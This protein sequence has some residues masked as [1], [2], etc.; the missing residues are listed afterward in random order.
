MHLRCPI[1]LGL[2]EAT[3]GEPVTES[4]KK[5]RGYKAELDKTEAV[6][7]LICFQAFEFGVTWV[8]ARCKR[9]FTVVACC[10]LQADVLRD[11]WAPYDI[12]SQVYNGG[13]RYR[14][15]VVQASQCRCARPN[16]AALRTSF[17]GFACPC[18][19]R[20]RRTQ[21]SNLISTFWDPGADGLRWSRWN[22]RDQVACLIMLEEPCVLHVNTC[23]SAIGSSSSMLG[24]SAILLLLL[25][26]KDY[27]WHP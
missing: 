24:R 11:E 7:A 9:D 10:M 27:L 21:T 4:F 23:A 2:I 18:N 5:R 16:S 14:R 26:A 3:T 19:W 25:M 6:L 13:F 22:A 8:N 1:T 15:P 12:S 17:S 20:M